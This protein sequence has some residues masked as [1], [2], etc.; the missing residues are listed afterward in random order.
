[1]ID[2]ILVLPRHIVDNIIMHADPAPGIWNLIS[3]YGDS[4]ELLTEG[5]IEILR[6]KG[7]GNY[8]SLEFWDLSDKEFDEVKADYPAAVLFDKE[9]AKKIIKF[10]EELQESDEKHKLIIHCDAGVS[11]SGAVGCFIN[12]VRGGSHD[13]L[14]LKNPNIL[15]SAYVSSVLNRVYREMI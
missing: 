3:I 9:H 10:V 2:S 14:M 8:L 12:D 15:P 13:M 4:E 7:L 1:M 6:E 5:A 11:R